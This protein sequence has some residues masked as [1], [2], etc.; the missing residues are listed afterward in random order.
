MVYLYTC[1]KRLIFIGL[2]RNEILSSSVDVAKCNIKRSP[3]DTA[4]PGVS[5]ACDP[6]PVTGHV[7]LTSLLY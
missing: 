5:Q 2:Q 1:N 4:T 6:I 3:I 7:F